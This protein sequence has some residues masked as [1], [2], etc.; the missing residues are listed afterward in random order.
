M[1]A[2][3]HPPKQMPGG[4]NKG[5]SGKLFDY[6]DKE[7]NDKEPEER[8]EF[9][10]HSREE[11]TY[12]DAVKMIDSNNKNLGKNDY[13]FY[14][15]SFNPSHDEQKHLAKI[16][17]GREVNSFKELSQD[18][19][20]NFL[21]QMKQF[22][23]NAMDE[24]AKNFGRENITSG[25]DLVYVGRVET[26]RTYKHFDRDVQ[27]NQPLLRERSELRQELNG[28]TEREAK[29]IN[30]RISVLETKMRRTQE[31]EII[32]KGVA[33]SGFN[34][35]VHVVV[36]RNDKTQ[37]T[38]LSPL[39]KSR[40]GKQT[41]QGKEVMQ[42]FNHERFKE[43][44]GEVF[45]EKYNYQPKQHEE[46]RRKSRTNNRQSI[47]S[48]AAAVGLN[49]ERNIKGKIKGIISE[50]TTN[51]M[52][53]QERRVIQSGIQAVKNSVMAVT[54]PKGAA[55]SMLKQAISKVISAVSESG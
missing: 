49:P 23:R 26:Q 28:A 16:V 50:H 1:F 17:S 2:K 35:H 43:R 36:S 47:G 12:A 22:S 31:G 9:F 15:V 25:S 48:V 11:V 30:E 7:N 53:T 42:G 18:E 3:V 46:Y 14:M 21:Y 37:T 27:Y 40:G 55:V 6:L 33:K 32:S 4:D 44:V 10:D 39:S 19:Q 45:N 41:F 24:Y 54:N 52:L 8:T 20:E 38:K 34:V 51:N 29:K 5:G 13:K